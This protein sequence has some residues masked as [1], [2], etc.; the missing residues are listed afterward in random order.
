MLFFQDEKDKLRDTLA[1]LQRQISNLQSS[2]NYRLD[3]ITKQQWVKNGFKIDIYP[4]GV[5]KDGTPRAKPGRKPGVK[6]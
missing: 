1:S 3:E 2:M 4:Y 6:A 5:K